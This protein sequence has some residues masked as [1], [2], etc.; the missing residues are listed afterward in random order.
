[1]QEGSRRGVDAEEAGAVTS[2]SEHAVAREK[3]LQR[4]RCLLDARFS[5][6]CGE[7]PDG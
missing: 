2:E 6:L 3:N 4:R 7:A 1:M 5:T